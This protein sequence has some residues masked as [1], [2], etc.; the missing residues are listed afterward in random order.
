VPVGKPEAFKKQIRHLMNVCSA[1]VPM[2]LFSPQRQQNGSSDWIRIDRISSL[3]INTN[4]F[5][6]HGSKIKDRL[7][8]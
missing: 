6:R 8:A 1:D 3:N 4:F 2:S 5:R 7:S